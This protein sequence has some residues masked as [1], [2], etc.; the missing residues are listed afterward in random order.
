MYVIR[1][2]EGALSGI[3]SSGGRVAAIINHEPRAALPESCP[4]PLGAIISKLLAFQVEHRYATAGEIR[5]DLERLEGLHPSEVVYRW[6]LGLARVL[7]RT[8]RWMLWNV[9]AETPLVSAIE[10]RLDP[11]QFV[12]IHRSTIVNVTRVREIRPHTHGE[13]VLV[14]HDGTK[15][16]ASRSYSDRVRAFL[17]QIS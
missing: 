10:E 16:K 7:E 3:L 9:E 2:G 11:Q 4:P 17:E 12:R 14:L 1:A 5:A 15:L 6:Q 8:T 13:Y